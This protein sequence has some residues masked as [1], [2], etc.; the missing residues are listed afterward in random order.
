MTQV[1]EARVRYQK[2]VQL[3][4]WNRLQDAEREAMALIQD[5]PEDAD[6]YALLGYVKH[7][8][9][10]Y[11]E[12]HHWVEQALRR[13]P[14]HILGWYVRTNTFYEQDNMKA[15]KTALEEALR[16]DPYEPHYHMLNANLCNK[17][18]KYNEAKEHLLK[19]LEIAPE[20][21]FY[22]AQMSYTEALL[23]NSH[24]SKEYEKESLRLDV[25]SELNY[26]YLA[27]AADRRDD[28]EQY[29]LML[30]NAIHLDPDNKQVREEYMEGLQSQ[31][32]LYRILM[33]PSRLAKRLKPWQILMCWFALWIIFRPLVIIF[34]ILYV[35]IHWSTK[36]LVHVK[37]FGW[38]FKRR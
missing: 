36:L 22:L 14:E 2:V 1:D 33:A 13:E 6:N 32:L 35:I 24:I 4:E 7:K 37:L 18:G 11:E 17:K 9:E 12:A 5:E 8:M 25:E 27:W 19:A 21:A 30:K 31:Y 15:L 10:K 16:I 26:L 38:N 20:N 23:G 29:L 34:I 3:M 28:N